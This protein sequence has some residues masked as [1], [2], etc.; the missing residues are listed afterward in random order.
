MAWG[1]LMH[2]EPPKTEFQIIL[3]LTHCHFCLPTTIML[4]VYLPPSCFLLQE[5]NEPVTPC[6]H[7]SF[8]T[9]SSSCLRWA[10][11]TSVT[12][13]SLIR[14]TSA[15]SRTAVWVAVTGQFVVHFVWR[16][17]HWN[18]VTFCSCRTAFCTFWFMSVL[19]G[20]YSESLYAVREYVSYILS[21]LAHRGPS[22]LPVE[23]K[24]V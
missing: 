22:T 5:S 13:P 23:G 20:C 18:S 7:P 2:N 11:S 8:S 19:L 1:V 14:S 4:S 17:R 10:S 3:W 12:R 9:R 21:C 24:V 6:T 16:Q 15:T